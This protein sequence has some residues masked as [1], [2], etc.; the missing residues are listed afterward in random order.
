MYFRCI[1]GIKLLLTCSIPVQCQR[2]DRRNCVRGEGRLRVHPRRA[3]QQDY[4][5]Q[6]QCSAVPL[7][8]SAR[9]ARELTS[10]AIQR[11]SGMTRR[12]TCPCT[13]TGTEDSCSA[14]A[15]YSVSLCMRRRPMQ[16]ENIPTSA[17]GT[18][19][20]WAG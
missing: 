17:P 10:W 6:R 1:N 12:A 4:R 18:M 19:T 2:P 15:T 5:R 16:R 14:P 8:V 7:T 3:G 11:P 20:V 13:S 9:S